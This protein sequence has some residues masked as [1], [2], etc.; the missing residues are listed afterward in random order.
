MHWSYY[1]Q[2]NCWDSP[3]TDYLLSLHPN[4]TT[5]HHA[6]HPGISGGELHDGIDD[7]LEHHEC[8]FIWDRLCL[9]LPGN[10]ARTW[11]KG[12]EALLTHI[13]R[14]PQKQAVQTICFGKCSEHI[15]ELGQ[16]EI[17]LLNETIIGCVDYTLQLFRRT[18]PKTS[19]WETVQELMRTV[20]KSFCVLSQNPSRA[21]DGLLDEVDRIETAL[22]SHGTAG[23]RMG[24]NTVMCR[25]MCPKSAW[26]KDR[27]KQAI[28]TLPPISP[29]A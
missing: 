24:V 8:T 17:Q 28:Q 22:F 4:G 1:T 3:F 9:F 11:S 7:W 23:Q 2:L 18:E 15:E 14:C 26:I 16:S 13:S 21:S 27:A 20:K 6:C 25:K 19:K 5:C 29:G 10:H 12:W